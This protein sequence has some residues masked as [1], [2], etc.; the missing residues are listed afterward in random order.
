MLVYVRN[1]HRS[2]R[3]YDAM[4]PWYSAANEDSAFNAYYERPATIALLGSVTGCCV[5][6]IGCGAGPLTNWLVDHGAIVTAM[7]VSSEMLRLAKQR[8]GDRA[9]FILAD[10]AEPLSF[11]SDGSFDLV[12]ASL[13]L[14]YIEDWQPIL[15]EFRRILKAKGAIVFSTHHPAMDWEH[16]ADDYFAVK[17]VTELWRE[18][19]RDFEV[20]FWR[21]P[22]TAMTEAIS[23][24]GLVIERVVE[25]QPIPELRA[26][27]PEA[28]EE[29]TTKPR[30]LFFRLAARN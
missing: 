29:I 1:G 6:D 10:A 23:S 26:R 19:D 2:A 20:T 4:A 16:S 3:Q 25:P 9:A 12:V 15:Q 14:H 8:V 5:L 28:Y 13:V 30:F 22:L 27:D 24:S 11:A 18:V 17:Q 7:D 21:R